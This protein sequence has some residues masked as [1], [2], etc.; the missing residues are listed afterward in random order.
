MVRN[1]NFEAQYNP[2]SSKLFTEYRGELGS[3]CKSCSFTATSYLLCMRLVSCNAACSPFST[4][5]GKVFASSPTFFTGSLAVSSDEILSVRDLTGASSRRLT[6]IFL[7]D[8]LAVEGLSSNDNDLKSSE[9]TCTVGASSPKSSS[10]STSAQSCS[11]EV[12]AAVAIV[13][14]FLLRKSLSG[15]LR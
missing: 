11:C 8:S 9:S 10:S 7:D 6:Q 12:L 2:S 5:G 1:M 14:I 3:A 13:V 15:D 4:T